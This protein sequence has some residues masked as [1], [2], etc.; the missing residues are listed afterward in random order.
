MFGHVRRDTQ[1]SAIVKYVDLILRMAVAS[2]VDKIV[3]GQPCDDLPCKKCEG[4]E[5]ILPG[6]PEGTL[7]GFKNTKHVPMWQRIDGTWHELP[8]FLWYLLPDVV[9]YVGDLIT[10]YQRPHQQQDFPEEMEATIPLELP[11]PHGAAMVSL[12]LTMEPNYC[13][14]NIGGAGRGDRGF[15]HDAAGDRGVARAMAGRAH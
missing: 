14:S 15:H 6:L 8:G 10:R 9:R 13:Y 5:A 3:F 7:A 1:A 2:G 11:P 12:T 4:I